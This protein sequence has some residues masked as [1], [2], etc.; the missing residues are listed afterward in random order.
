MKLSIKILKRANKIWSDNLEEILNYFEEK[1]GS[2]AKEQF[3]KRL[4][5]REEIKK[6]EKYVLKNIIPK[7][8]LK[9]DVIYESMKD[10]A[11]LCRHVNEARWDKNEQMF[12]YKRSKFG[13]VF[14]DTMHHFS[15]VIDK[16][17]AGFTPIKELNK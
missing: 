7:E 3:I 1:F 15:D 8:K 10:T 11:S 13:H 9:H 5:E 6:W 12:W 4:E 17:I 2:N 14:E 16:G